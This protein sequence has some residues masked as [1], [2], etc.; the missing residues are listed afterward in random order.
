[1]AKVSRKPIRPLLCAREYRL[2]S[3]SLLDVWNEFDREDDRS[4]LAK[5]LRNVA[6]RDN[7]PWNK[8]SDMNKQWFKFGS[9]ARGKC[10]TLLIHVRNNGPSAIID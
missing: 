1:M 3:R 7:R 10:T 4:D 5:I 9:Y 8:I 6:R 2:F